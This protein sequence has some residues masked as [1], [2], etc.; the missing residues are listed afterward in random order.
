MATLRVETLVFNFQP[1]IAA[2]KYDDSVHY[3][4]AWRHRHGQKAVDVV[5]M[6]MAAVP[7]RVWLIEAKD[8]R[9]ITTPPEPSNNQELADTV[10][11]K[12]T[13]T[14]AGLADAAVNANDP[15][16]K[17]HAARAMAARHR[18]IVLHLEPHVGHHTKLF[19]RN[20]SGNVLQ[21]LKRLVKH[22]DPKPLV[23]NI[24]TT[25]RARVP[26]AVS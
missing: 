6:R 20:F 7:D 24:A 17:Q 25:R 1:S 13:H 18:R 3:L 9:I 12:V 5:A 16:E 22:I 14:L 15:G 11:T 19:P 8:F 10:L 4:T 26:W 2:Q 23:L 21:Q